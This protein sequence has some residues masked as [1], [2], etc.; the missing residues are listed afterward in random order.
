MLSDEKSRLGTPGFRIRE[1]NEAHLSLIADLTRRA[2]STP[3]VPTPG[4]PAPGATRETGEGIVRELRAGTRVFVL[5]LDLGAGR[6]RDGLVPAGIVRV[7]PYPP[8]AWLV[9]RFGVLPEYRGHGAGTLLLSSIEN[10]ARDAGV[11]RLVLYCVVERL[12][13]PYYQ[14]R[15]FKVTAIAPHT[16]KPLTVATMEKDIGQE[17]CKEV[18]GDSVTRV[19]PATADADIAPEWGVLPRSG[20]YVLWLYVP[21]PSVVR[22]GSLG[23]HS[24]DRGLYAYVGSGAKGL[25]H[26][27]R[28]HWTGDGSRRWHVDWLRAVARPVG[29]DVVPIVSDVANV[30][31]VVSLPT[32]SECGLA[33]SLSRVA[34]AARVATRFGASDCG[35]AGHLLSVPRDST[36]YSLPRSWQA[37][38]LCC[39]R[40]PYATTP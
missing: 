3:H 1:L 28:R 15:G 14:Q 10:Q 18:C 30:S 27:L 9:S 5:H 8:D 32:L 4:L 31:S 23:E 22:I 6:N 25:S 39:Y 35:C 26:H 13:V 19:T 20:L 38:L 16:E 17:S 2:F 36:A 34:G 33:D 40:H 37:G 11:R 29:I 21:K 24:L 12:L 7:T